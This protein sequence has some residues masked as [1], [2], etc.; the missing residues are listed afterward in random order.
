VSVPAPVYYSQLV[1]QRA[2]H[3]LVDQNESIVGDNKYVC[4][5]A[6]TCRDCRSDLQLYH[7][8]GSAEARRLTT[9]REHAAR[10]VEVHPRQ[11]QVMYFA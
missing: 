5:R 9:N 1:L 10:A 11:S 4:A 6:H 3:Y 7:R 8:A 2:R